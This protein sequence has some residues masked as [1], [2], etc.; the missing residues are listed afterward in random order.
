MSTLIEDVERIAVLR[1]NAVGDY[2]FALPA[3]AALR[4]AYP[5]A[6]ITLLG[7]RWHREFFAGRPSAIDEV[8]EMPAVPGVGAALDQSHDQARVE[9]F[10]QA[11]HARRFDLVFQLY[12][13]G[14]Y[15]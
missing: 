10:V 12:G 14:R 2:M 6:H 4:A 9:D 5:Q 1:P 11:M 7:K 3:L 15:S 13:G 8:I